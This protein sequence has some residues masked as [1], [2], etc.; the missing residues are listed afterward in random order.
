MTQTPEK[1]KGYATQEGTG[2]YKERFSGQF[3]EGHFRQREGLWFSSLGIGSYLG[4]ADE[5][6]DHAYEEALK[7]AIGSGI[8]VADSAI[9]YRH[10]RSERNFG[11]ALRQL[12]QENKIKREEI[13]LCTKGGFIPFDEDEPKNLSAYLKSTYVDTGLLHAGDVAQSC[14]AI[15]P[16]YLEDQLQRSLDNLG[17]ETI[18]I[19]YLHNPETQLADFDRKIF[20]ERL[21]L[22]FEWLEEK[23]REGKIKR[24]GTATWQGYRVPSEQKEYL[25]LEE[26]SLLAREAGGPGHHFKVVQLPFNLAMPEAWIFPNQSYGANQVSLLNVA[27]RY[28][29]TVIASA[30]LLQARLAGKL[31]EFFTRHFPGF[32]HSSQCAL[33]FVRSV[34]GVTTALVGMKNKA[35]IKE[36]LDTVK[37][38]PLSEEELVM[39]FQKAEE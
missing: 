26:I 15:T 8:N 19:Y 39:I 20:S 27:E 25:G 2:S 38:P 1:I 24:Y 29:I 23:V 7:E 10:Q 33:Q 17:V 22:A 11:R 9:N 14:H 3:A 32:K 16:V 5:A 31:P 35:H 18:D 6:T 28:G 13:I 36:N 34:P 21:R 30:S 4:G 12:I 37:F